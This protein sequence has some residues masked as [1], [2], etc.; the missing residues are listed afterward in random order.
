MCI[1]DSN[2]P[3]LPPFISLPFFP[4]FFF[5]H[6]FSKYTHSIDPGTFNRLLEYDWKTCS[7]TFPSSLIS[8]SFI[9]TVKTLTN[10]HFEGKAFLPLNQLELIHPS[11]HANNMVMVEVLIEHTTW[12]NKTHP[13]LLGCVPTSYVVEASLSISLRAPNDAQFAHI[14][15][16][17]TKIRPLQVCP[18]HGIDPLNWLARGMFTL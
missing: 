8:S 10:T 4:S 12:I 11:L 15:R 1:R 16:P 5:N 9:S 3:P 6:L 14:W 18:L 7:T 2:T 17:R 13:M